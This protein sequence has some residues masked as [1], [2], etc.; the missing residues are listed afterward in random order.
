MS[1]IITPGSDTTFCVGVLIP[2]G[3]D[4]PTTAV[5]TISDWLGPIG[6]DF[7]AHPLSFQLEDARGLRQTLLQFKIEHGEVNWSPS[8]EHTYAVKIWLRDGRQ[9]E[10]PMCRGRV[11]Y[12]TAGVEAENSPFPSIFIVV[13]PAAATATAPAASVAIS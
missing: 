4:D 5:L 13:A 8:T 9:L 6:A 3:V 10:P 2:A 12:S 11:F 1:L 7:V